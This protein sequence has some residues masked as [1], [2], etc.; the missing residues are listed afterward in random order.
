MAENLRQLQ[1]F[2]PLE[3]RVG[4]MLTP[5]VRLLVAAEVVVLYPLAWRQAL[6]RIIHERSAASP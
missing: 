1:D 6:T 2:Q 3:V 5:N 4:S